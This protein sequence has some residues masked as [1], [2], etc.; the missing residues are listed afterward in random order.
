MWG[1]LQQLFRRQP[2]PP[3]PEPPVVQVSPEPTSVGVS[4]E[5]ERRDFTALAKEFEQLFA[6]RP[7]LIALVTEANAGQDV[8]GVRKLL[9]DA[10]SAQRDTLRELLESLKPQILQFNGASELK[11]HLG[12][13]LTT[14]QNTLPSK[15]P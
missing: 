5:R 4:L 7:D 6:Y 12:V 10:V 13:L 8:T 15:Q 14:L 1:K 3:P 9:Q 11:E 2:A